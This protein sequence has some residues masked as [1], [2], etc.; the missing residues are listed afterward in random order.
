[1]DSS[2]R[3]A[4]T[5]GDCSWGLLRV[6]SALLA[7][8]VD[9]LQE[10]IACPPQLETLPAAAPGLCGAVR[11]RGQVLPVLCLRTVLG[12][13]PRDASDVCT[14]DST[15]LT[16]VIL[17]MRHQGC[18]LGLRADAVQGMARIPAQ[19]VQALHTLA[20]DT[21]IA[22][23]AFEV[24]EQLA[25]VLE[26]A[27]IAALPGVPMVVARAPATATLAS[28][29]GEALL[30]FRCAGVPL[31]LAA[32]AV[33]GTVPETELVDSPLRRGACLGVF[34]HHGQE[35]AAVDLAALLGLAPT[36]RG[37][38]GE[39]A[40]GP[41]LPRSPL[42]VLRTAKGLV[43]LTM[44]HV[45]DIVRV[46]PSAV[47]QLPPLGLA[48]R[49]LY[50]GLIEAAAGDQPQASVSAGAAQQR[51]GNTPHLL[52]DEEALVTHEVLL[53]L[54]SLVRP[55]PLTAAGR[56]AQAGS[57]QAGPA[58]TMPGRTVLTYQAGVETASALIQV[59]EIIPVPAGLV[60]A[61][62]PHSHTLGVF[63]HRGATLPLVDL[64]SL[65]GGG[66]HGEEPVD[67]LSQRVLIV[68]D[69]EHRVGLRVDGL[70][71]IETARWEGHSP[72]HDSSTRFDARRFA[73]R[74]PMVE[75]GT[76]HNQRT[77][78]CLDLHQL[79]RSLHSTAEAGAT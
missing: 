19:A 7:L 76:A 73:T 38:P 2:P 1:M 35:V 56:T 30:Q 51:G 49:A 5:G 57:G 40:A 8:Q 67:V 36:P 62:D 53:A 22:T 42:L 27:R 15:A 54:S 43:G 77:L 33:D 39:A 24:G 25:T 68:D 16:G 3:S 63:T 71:T 48:R 78:A 79:V 21:G 66:H 18:L 72:R 60:S 6:G 20:A 64:V 23:H 50:R 59:R 4:A 10:V 75:L 29:H 44:D 11:L 28:A 65:L 58:D 13:P 26:P 41:G 70:G 14:R 34:Q 46:A 17:L 45:S 74:P 52:L 12:L 69:G 55:T 31:A 47:Q 9:A 32:A 61:P 37:A